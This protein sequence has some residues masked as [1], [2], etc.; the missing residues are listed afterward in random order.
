MQGRACHDWGSWVNTAEDSCEKE[1][2]M[3]K[4]EIMEIWVQ[5]LVQLQLCLCTNFDKSL[6]VFV[7]VLPIF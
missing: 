2:L 6:H 5:M 4:A 1:E 7:T 3:L